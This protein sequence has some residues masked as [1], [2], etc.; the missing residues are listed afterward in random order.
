MHVKNWIPCRAKAVHTANHI[1][2]AFASLHKSFVVSSLLIDLISLIWHWL[3]KCLSSKSTQAWNRA[4]PRN[5]HIISLWT[6]QA[7]HANIIG[8]SSKGCCDSY[9]FFEDPYCEIFTCYMYNFVLCQLP[10]ASP[11]ESSYINQS[12]KTTTRSSRLKGA[13][14]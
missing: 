5:K 12:T 3:L 13:K 11:S 1:V 7:K 8:Q 6:I 2:S 14:P 4:K 9:L 10:V